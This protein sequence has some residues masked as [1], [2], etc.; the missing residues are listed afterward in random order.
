MKSTN[1]VWQQQFTSP[2]SPCTSLP[3]RGPFGCFCPLLWRQTPPLS[4]GFCFF[5]LSWQRLSDPR[6]PLATRPRPGAISTAFVCTHTH[7]AGFFN[8][9]ITALQH[10]CIIQ[11]P[12]APENNLLGVLK[13]RK[14]EKSALQTTFTWVLNA[15]C[16]TWQPLA[17]S[18]ASSVHTDTK[19]HTLILL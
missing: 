18:H 14:K 7:R 6:L 13:K 4:R 15:S 9:S 19:K 5:C 2:P 12:V 16:Q 11:N 10:F 1:T 8:Y 17:V 3:P